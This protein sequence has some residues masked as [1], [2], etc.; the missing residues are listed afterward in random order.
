VEG[1]RGPNFLHASKSQGLTT[2]YTNATT[3][4]SEAVPVC[5]AVGADSEIA[6]HSSLSPPYNTRTE[7]GFDLAVQEEQI[8]V[9]G[10]R[11]RTR[12]RPVL[13]DEGISGTRVAA[14]RPGLS[15]AG[16][17]ALYSSSC[18]PDTLPY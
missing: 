11:P 9:V 4:C 13:R 2:T 12:T 5:L 6:D 3:S 1:T 15:D 16:V 10:A 17:P 14:D 8:P 18:P 7:Q